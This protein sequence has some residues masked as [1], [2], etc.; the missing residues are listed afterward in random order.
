MDLNT[1]ISALVR[2]AIRMYFNYLQ[3]VGIIS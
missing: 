3:R 2:E 1:N